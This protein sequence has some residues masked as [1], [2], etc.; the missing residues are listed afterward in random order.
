MSNESTPTGKHYKVFQHSKRHK[1]TK[2]KVARNVLS[3]RDPERDSNL[4][5]GT[6]LDSN[7]I[8]VKSTPLAMQSW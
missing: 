1:S 8:F 4:N 5:T 7:A 3:S 6:M 2:L